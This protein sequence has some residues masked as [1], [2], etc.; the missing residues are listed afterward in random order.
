MHPIPAKDLTK[1]APASPRTRVGGYAILARALDK[2]RAA[3][4]GTDGEYHYDCPLDQ[5]LFSF[6]NVTGAE[7]LSLLEA[8]RSDEEIASWID[9]HGTPK[10]EEEKLAWSDSLEAMRPF[11]NPVMK[12]W[13]VGVCAEAGI[14]PATSTLFDYLEVDDQLSYAQ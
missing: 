7:I 3:I 6:K 9:T 11:N 12:D 1:E 8:G 13:F 5:D 10:T 14:D 4:A 2:G